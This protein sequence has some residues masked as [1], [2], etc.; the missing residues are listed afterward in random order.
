[1]AGNVLEELAHD[2]QRQ[3][4]V[5]GH[6]YVSD[7]AYLT[8]IRFTQ[9]PLVENHVNRSAE[10]DKTVANISEHDC[11]EERERNDRKKSRVNLLVLAD[12]VAIHDGLEGFGEFIGPVERGWSFVCPQLMKDRRNASPRL[13]L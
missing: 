13:F 2:L 12:T 5:I 3:D 7:I 11:E 9:S 1:M 4:S 8:E 10:D 6:K